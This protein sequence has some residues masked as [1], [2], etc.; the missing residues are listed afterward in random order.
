VQDQ[1]ACPISGMVPW[2]GLRYTDRMMRLLKA[3]QGSPRKPLVTVTWLEEKIRLMAW[4]GEDDGSLNAVAE[5]SL[6]TK[7][8]SAEAYR[9]V[10]REIETE[11]GCRRSLV[12]WIVLRESWQNGSQGGPNPPFGIRHCWESLPLAFLPSRTLEGSQLLMRAFDFKR[13]LAGPGTCLYFRLGDRALLI[14]EGNGVEFRRLSRTGLLKSGPENEILQDWFL[15]SRTLFRNRT[16]TPLKR[17]A[18]PG[19]DDAFTVPDAYPIDIDLLKTTRL[20]GTESLSPVEFILH[21]QAAEAGEE[22]MPE[23]PV[24]FLQSR[25]RSRDWEGRFRLGAC[26]LTGGWT[27]LVMGACRNEVLLP[28]DAIQSG[29]ELDRY[30]HRFVAYQQQ[31]RAQEE[32]IRNVSNPFDF[33]GR[34]L[35]SIPGEIRMSGLK[36]RQS[37]GNPQAYEVEMRGALTTGTDTHLLRSWIADLQS[38]GVLTKVG[39][40]KFERT[41][42]QIAFTLSGQREIQG[43]IR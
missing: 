3:L 41:A 22:T 28:G 16:G 35:H 5:R 11:A 14:G 25:R 15:Q 42:N 10:L 27:L 34:L 30:Q 37:T 6:P 43:A 7:G 19:K 9:D 24:P 29:K 20:P 33:S 39:D 26:L 38:T 36:L 23:A 8:I 32:R 12:R 13:E 40:L 18:I 17:I 4:V 31:W 1:G 21:K 2:G